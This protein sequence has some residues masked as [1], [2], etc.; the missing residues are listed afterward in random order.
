MA[1]GADKVRVMVTISETE[2]QQLE[3]ISK[4]QNRN[5]SNLIGTIIKE[6]LNEQK[7]DQK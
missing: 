4:L 5:L 7:A 2:K 3:E 6:Y 1:I